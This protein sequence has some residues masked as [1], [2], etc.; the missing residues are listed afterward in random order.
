MWAPGEGGGG[1]GG[2]N[3]GSCAAQSCPYG[4]PSGR[5]QVWAV[6]PLDLQV[7]A[8]AP[9]CPLMR[10]ISFRLSVA[11]L[12]AGA[13]RYRAPPALLLRTDLTPLPS[14]SHPWS[15]PPLPP[16]SQATGL[17]ETS[18]SYCR[19]TDLC[20]PSVP[21][22][23]RQ[24]AGPASP[25]PNPL[26]RLGPEPGSCQSMQ[27][28]FRSIPSAICVPERPAAPSGTQRCPFP[29]GSSKCSNTRHLCA[30]D[31]SEVWEVGVER[32]ARRPAQCTN[33]KSALTSQGDSAFLLGAH[34]VAGSHSPSQSLLSA[35]GFPL[36]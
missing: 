20:Q 34:S 26:W 18:D 17:L 14:E 35:P 5:E 23:S 6:P 2:C 16:T 1:T 11:S 24:V 13:A 7:A 9:L 3:R 21:K 22:A 29:L 19:A 25:P 31:F 30:P 32:F 27:T 15:P 12:P 8:R 10:P 28:G 36:S 4:A 33:R